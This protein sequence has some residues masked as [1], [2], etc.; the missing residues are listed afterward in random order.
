MEEGEKV[1]FRGWKGLGCEE[2]DEVAEVIAA[3]GVGSNVNDHKES[4]RRRAAPMKRDPLSVAR[5]DQPRRNHKLGEIVRRDPILCVLL[6]VYSRLLQQ[7][8]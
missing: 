8:Y 5:Q 6:E 7:V 1:V 4:E 2:F 3:T